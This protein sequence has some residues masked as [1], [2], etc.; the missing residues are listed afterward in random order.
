MYLPDWRQPQNYSYIES[1][2][3]EQ[4]AWEVLRRNRGYQQDW[5][6]FWA[7]WRS[8]EA[9]YGKPPE[10]D[11]QRWK[12]DPDAYRIVDEACGEWRLSGNV[13]YTRLAC[14]AD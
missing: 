11:F 9:R 14:S 5:Q 4:W 12:R 8:L 6:W 1:L 3:V 10:R 7:T 2:S 13:T